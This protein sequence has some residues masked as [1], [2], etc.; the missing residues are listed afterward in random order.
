M[1]LAHLDVRLPNI[2]FNEEFEVVFIDIEFNQPVNQYH[3]NAAS[4]LYQVPIS[5]DNPTNGLINFMQVGWILA[6]ILHHV[7]KEHRRVWHMQ[8]EFV[9]NNLFISSLVTKCEYDE[10]ALE[11]YSSDT[12]MD[13]LRARKLY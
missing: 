13:V 2:C 5:V 6:Y 1:E 10:K 12:I 3:R 11:Q 9:R 8:S 4:C 7:K